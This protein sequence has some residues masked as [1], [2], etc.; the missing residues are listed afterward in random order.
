MSTLISTLIVNFSIALGVVLGGSLVGG[1]GALLGG[2]PPIQTTLSIAEKLKIWALVASLG[3]TFTAIKEIEMGFLDAQIHTV[4]KQLIFIFGAFM[5]AHIGVLIISL[6][7]GGN[8][9]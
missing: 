3:G 4:I 6:M 5:G 8:N 7:L 2:Q 9:S 1:L